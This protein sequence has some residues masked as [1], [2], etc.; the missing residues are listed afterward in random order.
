MVLV[1]LLHGFGL[2]VVDMVAIGASDEHLASSLH[3]MGQ[4]DSNNADNIVKAIDIMM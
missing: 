3:H 2:V 1:W 4:K